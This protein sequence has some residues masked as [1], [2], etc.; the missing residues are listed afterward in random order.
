MI[1]QKEGRRLFGEDVGNYARYRPPYPTA[2]FTLLQQEKGLFPNANTLEIGAGGGQATAV[3]LEHGANPI[4]LVE[5]DA[6]FNSILQQLAQRHDAAATILNQPFEAV[7]LAPNSFDLAVSATTFHWVGQQAGLVK[8]GQL[9]RSGGLWAMWWT[10]FGDPT[11]PD[12]FRQAT[13][14]LLQ[15]LTKSP[16]HQT[17]RPH[18]ALDKAQRTADLNQTG[19][20]HLPHIE[21]IPWTVRLDTTQLRGLYATFS[22]IQKQPVAERERILDG[23]VEIAEKEFDGVVKRPFLTVVYLSKR[24]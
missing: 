4:T 21:E 2:V 23:L 10:I 3:L 14:G 8:V 9:L 20:F 5:P 17:P 7:A 1:Q 24:K 13:D 16:S 12:P 15:S 19:L 6:R 22:P 11:R 18:F